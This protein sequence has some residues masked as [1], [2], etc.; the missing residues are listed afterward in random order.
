MTSFHSQAELARWARARRRFLQVSTAGGALLMAPRMGFAQANE[1]T[2]LENLSAT[3]PIFHR[4]AADCLASTKYTLTAAAAGVGGS[5]HALASEARAYIQSRK[6]ASA[7]SYTQAAKGL[8]ASPDQVSH[9]FG[10]YAAIRPEEFLALDR[11]GQ[12]KRVGGPVAPRG[13]IREVQLHQTLVS[14]LGDTEI[15]ET[16]A[17][18]AAQLLAAEKRAAAKEA[19]KVDLDDGLQYDTLVLM[20]D[21]ITCERV[22]DNPYYDGGDLLAVG[23]VAIGAT[24]HHVKIGEQLVAATHNVGGHA[25][26]ITMYPGGEMVSP[27]KKIHFAAFQVD[28]HKPFPHAYGVSLAMGALGNDEKNGFADFLDK[29]WDHV[30]AFIESA[31]GDAIVEAAA[32][33]VLSSIPFIGTIIGA[34]VGAVINWLL[35][36]CHH[37]NP[38]KVLGHHYLQLNQQWVSKSSYG[39]LVTGGRKGRAHY[40]H[41]GASYYVDYAWRMLLPNQKTIGPIGII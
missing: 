18:T 33:T 5:G 30:K 35:G 6:T 8:L 26:A 3:D 11:A 38:D 22:T 41:A 12:I 9:A 1:P 27:L 23:G 7:A 10:R 15:A 34:I 21:R 36:L 4:I 20:I 16:P 29:V 28:K 14:P 13:A 32:I 39:D 19:D 25:G 24:G 40:D 17:A 31:I 37:A 2:G